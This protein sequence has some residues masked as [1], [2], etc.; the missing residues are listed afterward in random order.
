MNSCT[1]LKKEF[2]KINNLGW[3]KSQSHGAGNAGITFENLIGKERENFQIADYEGIEIKT[4]IENSLT[5]NYITLFSSA[6]NGKYLHETHR[7]LKTYGQSYNDYHLFDKF[8]ARISGKKARMINGYFMKVKVGYIEKRL[9]LEIYDKNF[10]LIDNE[11]YW[12]FATIEKI[13]SNKMKLLAYITVERKYENRKV[14]FHYK[15]IN[16]YQSRDF[17]EFL[18]LIEEGIIQICFKVGVYKSGKKIGNIY[19]HGTGFEISKK[20]LLRLYNKIDF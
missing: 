2:E 19:D 13:L 11:S 15:R 10:N 17:Y 18:K 12:D 4:S 9:I 8:Y 20:N 6:P 7:L 5:R 1:Q 14:Y 3:I 16:F